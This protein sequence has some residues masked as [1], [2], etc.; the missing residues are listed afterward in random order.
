LTEHW[1]AAREKLFA[2]HAA[3][4]ITVA[5]DEPGFKGLNGVYDA[6]ERLLSGHS[7]GKVL[8]D[9]RG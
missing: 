9:L 5:F 2:L 1:P 7:I 6:V 4:R 8:V 3:G